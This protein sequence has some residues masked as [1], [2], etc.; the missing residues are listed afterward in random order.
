MTLPA[1]TSQQISVITPTSRDLIEAQKSIIDSLNSLLEQEQLDNIIIN[2]ILLTA[3][4]ENWVVTGL[5]RP[6]RGWH[7]I[8]VSGFTRIYRY[9]DSTADLSLYLPLIT[10]NTVRVS[11]LIF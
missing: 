9:M 4:V 11:L 10:E 6:I 7:Q 2:D 1:L 3:G 8:D 5:G